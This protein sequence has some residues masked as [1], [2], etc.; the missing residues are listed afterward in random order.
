MTAETHAEMHVIK[1]KP[2]WAETVE[3]KNQDRESFTIGRLGYAK[4]EIFTGE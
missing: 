4:A 3:F 1:T 2:R